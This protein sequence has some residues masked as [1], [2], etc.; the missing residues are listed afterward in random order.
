MPAAR[1]SQPGFGVI[2]TDEEGPHEDRPDEARKPWSQRAHDGQ[3]EPGGDHDTWLILAGRGFGKTQAGVEWIA[4]QVLA[5]P[6]L[7]IALVSAT[8]E[9]A[10]D[11]M[12][13]GISGF[14]ALRPEVVEKWVPSRGEVHFVGGSIGKLF[15]GANPERFR[16]FQHHLAWCDELAKWRKAMD[17]WD[18]LQFGLRL[19][20][21]PKALVT[22]TPAS[23]EALETILA[24]R[25]TVVTR[26]TTFDNPH[27]PK[28]FLDKMLEL[29]GHTHKG[30]VELYGEMPPPAGA[31]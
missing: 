4:E 24:D 1:C 18:N 27:L 17:S 15:S 21:H 28:R 5:R 7:R 6:N 29:H 20:E 3:L 23:S 31:L 10:R 25:H 30:R 19:G 16:G 22:T 8:V 26:G 9:E 2:S 11:V 14:L 12:V 13:L